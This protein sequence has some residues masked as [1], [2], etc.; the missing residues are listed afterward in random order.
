VLWLCFAHMLILRCAGACG[1]LCS[2]AALVHADLRGLNILVHKVRLQQWCVCA[3]ANLCLEVLSVLLCC[4]AGARG[5]Q[6]V[7]HPG[8]QG[9]AAGVVCLCLAL[10]YLYLVCCVFCSAAVLVHADLSEYHI[11]MHK[12]RLQECHFP[13]C[14]L[15]CLG[16]L[17]VLVVGARN[18]SNYN[19]SVHKVSCSSATPLVVC[20]W[21]GDNVSLGVLAFGAL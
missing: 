8:A 15:L 16:S 4:S 10:L 19:I 21:S 5:P 7:Q 11:V 17:G 14:V 3:C 2:A 18:L 6:R 12:V 13:F 1:R 20:L 9:A